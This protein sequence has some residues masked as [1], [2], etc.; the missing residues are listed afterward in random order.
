MDHAKRRTTDY[1]ESDLRVGEPEDW[2]AGATGVAV[3]M[4]RSLERM[5]PSRTAR[6]LL[7]LNQA[8]GFDC[9]S[10]AWPDPDPGHRSVAEFCENGAKAVAEEATTDRAT[11]DFFARHSIAELDAR[12]EYWLGQQGRITHPMVK[13]PGDTHYRAI[14]W[15]DALALVG[16][17]LRAL[18]SPDEATFYTSG[19]A[20][21]EVAFAYQLFARAYGTNNLPDCSNMC[22]ESTSI[23]LQESIGIGKASVVMSD[24]ENAELIVIA[25]QNPGTNHPRMLTHLE[26]AKDRGAKILTINP[27]REAG[28]TRFKNP[29]RPKGVVGPG[30]AL[31][32]LHLPIRVNGDL[33]LFQAMGAL[34]VEWDALDHDFIERHTTGFDAWKAHVAD[35]DWSDVVASTGLT[36]E[37]ITEAAQMLRDS[38]STVFCWAMG[39]TQHRNGVATIKEITNLAL[40]QGGIGR[41]GA[42]LFPVRGHSNVQGDR[43]MGIWERVP[44]SFLDA[45]QEEFGF[46]PPREH[47]L[48]TVDS[49]RAMRDGKVRVFVGLGGNFAQATPDTDVTAAALR[50]TSLTVQISTKI[51]RSHLV[52]GET[53]LILPTLGRTEKDVQAGGPQ[54]ISV[55]DSTCSVHSSRGPLPPASPHLRSE[56]AI[57]TGIAE[58]TIGDRHGIDWAAM[59]RDYSRIREHIARV[60]PGCES[61]EVNARRPGG[62]VLPHPPRDTRTFPTESGSAE[63]AVSP[64][65]VLHVPDG[66]LLLQTLR[67]HDQFNTTIYG[68]SDRY[69]GIEDGRRVVFLH[70]EDIAAL[71]FDDGDHVDL[72]TRWDD[73]DVERCARDFRIVA[74]DTPRGTAAAY[75]PET[76]PLVPLDHTAEGSHQPASKSVII[77]LARSA[78]PAGGTGRQE[79]VSDDAGEKDHPQPKHLS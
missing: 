5:G 44:D 77:S 46:D 67:S 69:R 58:A 79:G 49:V 47:G 37:Q 40:A 11:P 74:Y 19:R 59:R 31:S 50:S 24:L 28:L 73:D 35:I 45:I 64:V 18:G 15:D 2:A 60:V 4:K 1:D 33:A 8:E 3:S 68:L 25:G 72:T 39:I 29:Q 36:R 76:N 78:G 54:W 9:M 63:F 27:L 20:S 65:E 22:H 21:N 56:V 17:E 7:K 42:G 53:A 23:A 38:G 10:C 70:R 55:E 26:M 52:C 66:H 14:D 16:D 6:T 48:D 62:F 75:Y 13:R 41:P 51:N 32:D 43:T 57:I 30:T 12:S 34:L 71:G 61:Y